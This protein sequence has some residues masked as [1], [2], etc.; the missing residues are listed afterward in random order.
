MERQRQYSGL[1]SEARA[2]CL[3]SHARCAAQCGGGGY[4]FPQPGMMDP[5][6]MQHQAAMLGAPLAGQLA[7]QPLGF[8]GVHDLPP[9]F[10]GMD[11]LPPGFGGMPGM[12]G[13]R[14][15]WPTDPLDGP[16]G[17]A[18]LP[19]PPQRQEQ[20]RGR[21]G[22]AQH[23]RHDAGHRQLRGKGSPVR[24]RRNNSRFGG[25]RGRY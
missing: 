3:P 22:E 12:G 7:A 20:P 16:H 1:S 10:N 21:H 15:L 18:P 8:G 5:T 25:S 19:P 6:Y 4:G 17:P 14:P 13:S 9:G 24:G 2:E 11:L 23:P